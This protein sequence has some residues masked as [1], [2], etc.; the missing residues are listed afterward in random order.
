M[1]IIRLFCIICDFEVYFE[2]SGKIV[3]YYIFFVKCIY[4][5]F[6][7]YIICKGNRGIV[8]LNVLFEDYLMSG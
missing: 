4:Y 1:I 8:D 3:L 5:L 7:L 2:F 6:L